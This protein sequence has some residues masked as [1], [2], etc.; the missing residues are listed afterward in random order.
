MP[1]G[2]RKPEPA[3]K[4]GNRQRRNKAM[5]TEPTTKPKKTYQQHALELA[6][7]ELEAVEDG[8]VDLA[9]V[10]YAL[11]VIQRALEVQR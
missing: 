5:I 6:Q 8:K 4:E 1:A 10:R 2:G 11:R 9:F 7:R 3:G